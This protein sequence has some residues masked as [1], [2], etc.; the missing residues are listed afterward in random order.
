MLCTKLVS[1][2]LTTDS[3]VF[4]NKRWPSYHKHWFLWFESLGLTLFHVLSPWQRSAKKCLPLKINCKLVEVSE[5]WN[6]TLNCSTPYIYLCS[7]YSEETGQPT[8]LWT[9]TWE[10][11]DTFLPHLKQVGVGKPI[12]IL[13]QY[14]AS[15][16]IRIQAF[17]NTQKLNFY[18][19]Y[20]FW[21][22]T[23]SVFKR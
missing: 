14:F 8:A 6:V 2:F 21:N 4:S 13:I 19:S 1:S 11:I 12:R 5:V 15:M 23:I 20:F 3:K 10:K 9:V 17:A 18:A 7:L 22:S 16:R